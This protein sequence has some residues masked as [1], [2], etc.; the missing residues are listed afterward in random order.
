MNWL[1]IYIL[2]SSS[3]ANNDPFSTMYE[4]YARNYKE[5]MIYQNGNYGATPK[6]RVLA[7][8]GNGWLLF[9]HYTSKVHVEDSVVRRKKVS[10]EK[11]QQFFMVNKVE[12]LPDEIDLNYVCTEKVGTIAGIHPGPAKSLHVIEDIP[13]HTFEYKYCNMKKRISYKSPWEAL[14]ICPYSEERKK[15]IQLINA[16]QNLK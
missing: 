7:R 11:V 6:A 12:S 4:Q 15:L 2:L 13:Y 9:E 5:I 14:K 10:C 8:N 3:N 1:F 16:F